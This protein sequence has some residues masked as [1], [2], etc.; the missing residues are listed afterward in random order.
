M[1]KLVFSNKNGSLINPS[2][3]VKGDFILIN[4]ET[5]K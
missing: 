3:F 2:N 4:T 5:K 1:K